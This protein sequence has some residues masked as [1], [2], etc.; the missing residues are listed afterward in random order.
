MIVAMT[1]NTPSNVKNEENKAVDAAAI[2][3]QHQLV[4][5]QVQGG[6]IVPAP[7]VPNDVDTS[8][9]I[10]E[11]GKLFQNNKKTKETTY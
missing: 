7:E 2:V 10:A 3:E 4:Q 9:M 11:A 1:G 6:A 8:A 5:P